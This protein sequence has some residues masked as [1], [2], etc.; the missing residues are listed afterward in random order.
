VADRA[1]GLWH[2]A[3]LLIPGAFT[4]WFGF[5]AGGFFVGTPALVAIVLAGVLI[6]HL[7]TAEH[8]LAGLSVA[9]GVATVCLG[10]FALWTLLSGSWSDAPGRAQVEFGRVLLYLL[11]LVLFGLLPRVAGS[12]R[13]ML[14]GL[15]AAF[16]AIAGAGFLVRSLPETFTVDQSF[17]ADRLSYPTTY[18]N[19]TGLCAALAT[20]L[21][22]V[23]TMDDRERA[24]IR[25]AAAA[26]LPVTCAAVVL[27]LSRGAIAASALGLIVLLAAGRPR[28]APTAL[29][30]V[31]VPGVIAIAAAYG[32]DELLA[33]MPTAAPAVAQGKDLA[34]VVALCV[35]ASAALRLLVVPLDRRALR[36]TLPR[37][38]RRALAAA[39]GA[40][41]CLAL[42]AGLALGAPGYVSDQYDKFVEDDFQRG[43]GDSRARLTSAGNN[44]RL[45]LWDA[46]LDLFGER[47]LSG[48]GAGTFQT[49]WLQ[50]R[51]GQDDAVDAHSL[52]VETLA[53]LGL[54][55]VAL[56]GIPLL[57]GLAA[58][59]TRVRGPDRVIYAGALAL[60]VTWAVRSSIDWDWEM[61]VV[62]AWVFA[63]AGAA[64][65]AAPGGARTGSLGQRSRVLAAVLVLV[66]ALTPF[67]L[68]FSQ[69]RID[70]A[71]DAVKAGDCGTGIDTALQ[72]VDIAPDRAEPYELLAYCNVRLER[73]D[74]AE[75][76]AQRAIERDGDLWEYH[77]D[78][79][80]VRAAAGRDPRPAARRAL[81]LNPHGE[82]PQELVRAMSGDD[83]RKW[84]RRA[85]E[86]RLLI[87]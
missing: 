43:T 13:Q 29:L 5:H 9:L 66:L 37:V 79:A 56:L 23:L 68:A 87:P 26:A 54:V 34:P 55:G 38:S 64:L 2:A 20:L 40:V 31:V 18:S 19:T 27:T 74:L 81:E 48:S 51:P 71:A 65:A 85:L 80:L 42:A 72:A 63:V 45:D 73:H 52:A 62:T 32:S 47:P 14:R 17:L 50:R 41:A 70:R 61:P 53:E 22:L 76:Q 16:V 46:G 77:Y 24:W 7:T 39:V 58:L 35:L 36:M 69:S 10:L 67:Q 57:L 6:V 4:A 28:L 84:R 25:V 82:I 86:A 21:C 44:G 30:A 49:E 1:A 59:V 75:Q 15:A 78:L 12:L 33:D 83:P 3:L 60:A 8:P 11:V